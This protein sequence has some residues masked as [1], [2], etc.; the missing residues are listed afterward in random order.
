MTKRLKLS[1]VCFSADHRKAFWCV[2]EAGRLPL[3]CGEDFKVQ[4]RGLGLARALSR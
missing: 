1:F 4:E 3:G 2:D